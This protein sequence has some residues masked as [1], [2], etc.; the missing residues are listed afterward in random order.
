MSEPK[1]QLTPAEVADAVRKCRDAQTAQDCAGCP[2]HRAGDCIHELL[3]AAANVIE[4]LIEAQRW[5]P[6]TE[7]L[8]EVEEDTELLVIISGAEVPTTLYFNGQAGEDAE[9]YA[10][11]TDGVTFY[12]VSHWRPMPAGITPPRREGR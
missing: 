9:F 10:Y 7:H 2:F 8:P 4:E 1:K 6:V 5:I 3:Y 11:E 12:P